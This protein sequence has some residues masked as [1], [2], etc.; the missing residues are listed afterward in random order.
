[1][2]KD[3]EI[4]AFVKERYGKIAVQGAAGDGCS[5]SCCGA[6]ADIMEKARA[7]GYSMEDLKNI[8]ES[9][10]LG[11]GCGNPTAFAELKEGDVVVDLGSGAGVDVFLAARRVGDKGKAI[12]VDMTAEM[13]DKAKWNAAKGGF[14][15]VEFKLGEIEHLP[16]EDGS[17]DVIISNCVINLSV[18]KLATFKEAYRAL[19]PGGRILISDLVTE[20]ELPEEVRRSFEAWSKCVAGALDKREYL[21]TIR[22]AGFRE[23]GIVRESSY[24]KAELD[25]RLKAKIT[26]VQ[27]RAVK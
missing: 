23:V 3:D 16:V 8:P 22:R 20:G 25:E 17:V 11:L 26:S 21:D 6:S 12:G 7:R 13:I 27:V 1:M 14:T 10:F 9:A 4:K 19:R 18:D 24:D 15:N 5:P 2:A